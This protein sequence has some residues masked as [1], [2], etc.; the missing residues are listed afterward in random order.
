VHWIDRWARR[1]AISGELEPSVAP[2]SDAD[3]TRR[4][5]LQRAAVIGS[6]A[7]TVPVLQSVVAPTFAASGC[8]QAI[9]GIGAGCPRCAAGTPCTVNGECTTGICAGVCQPGGFGT[10]CSV[11]GDCITGICSS[12]TCQAGGVSTPCASN[13]DCTAGQCSGRTGDPKTCGGPGSTCSGNG[14]C[15]YGNCSGGNVCGGA[16]TA[17]STSTVCSP[18]RRC[19]FGV[20][21]AI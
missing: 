13:A 2:P 5:F 9:C 11:S 3:L 20:C 1:A 12:G 16:F 19:I 17:C 21:L 14:G 10:S 7:W 15:T 18:T 8:S 4:R 6:V